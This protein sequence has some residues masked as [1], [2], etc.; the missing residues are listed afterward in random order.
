MRRKFLP[1]VVLSRQEREALE[2]FVSC[3]NKNAREINRARI[4]LLSDAG[5]KIQE[6]VDLLHTSRPTVSTM[7][8]KY[9]ETDYAHILDI[10]K[11]APRSGRPVEIDARVEANITMIACSDPPEG[12]GSWTLRMIA[13]KVVE[14]NLVDGLSHESVRSVLKKTN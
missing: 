10:L 8:K 9:H 12:A 14:M 3:G 7:R 2:A 5:K 6:I 13:D 1:P 4:L 11:D